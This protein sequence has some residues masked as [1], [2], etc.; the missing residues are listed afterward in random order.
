MQKRF[1]IRPHSVSVGLFSAA[2]LCTAVP[3]WTGSGRLTIKD[4]ALRGRSVCQNDKASRYALNSFHLFGP[5]VIVHRFSRPFRFQ[6]PY[7]CP[8]LGQLRRSPSR[9]CWR[10]SVNPFAL[11]N[12]CALYPGCQFRITNTQAEAK[13]AVIVGTRKSKKLAATLNRN[14]MLH[15][16]HLLLLRPAKFRPGRLAKKSFSTLSLPI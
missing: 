8:G 11:T 16:D 6:T 14:R 7:L 5:M 3:A 13:A 12:I 15:S 10:Q 2:V 9:S 1:P 4:P